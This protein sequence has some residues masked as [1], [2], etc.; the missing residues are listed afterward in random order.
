MLS[1]ADIERHVKTLQFAGL[2]ASQRVALDALIGALADMR[3]DRDDLRTAVD[4]LEA[5]KSAIA[6]GWQGYI[7]AERGE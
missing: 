4:R 6:Q 3:K 1:Q 2:T 5:E 7:A